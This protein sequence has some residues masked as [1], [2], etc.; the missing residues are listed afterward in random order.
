MYIYT[1]QAH[2][3]TFYVEDESPETLTKVKGQT[4]FGH[5]GFHGELPMLR[6]EQNPVLLV[7]NLKRALAQLH[8]F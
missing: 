3:T 4:R 2:L 1:T 6:T 5:I 7:K 8:F